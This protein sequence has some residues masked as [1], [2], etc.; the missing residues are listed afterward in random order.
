M[1]VARRPAPRLTSQA[2]PKSASTTTRL[3]KGWSSGV[4][5]VRK[6]TSEDTAKWATLPAWLHPAA[7]VR[8]A[9]QA[10]TRRG[11]AGWRALCAGTSFGSVPVAALVRAGGGRRV[12]VLVRRR[13]AGRRRDVPRELL[14]AERVGEAVASDGSVGILGEA[15]QQPAVQRDLLRAVRPHGDAEALSEAVF[16][17]RLAV[18]G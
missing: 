2:S 10:W 13:D 15:V 11:R 8:R 14:V 6:S 18:D 7:A 9:R 1:K 3:P 5:S 12:R 4:C 16:A 17:G